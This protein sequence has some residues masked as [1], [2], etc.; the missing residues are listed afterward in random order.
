MLSDVFGWRLRLTFDA[1]TFWAHWLRNQE[2][3]GD[4]RLYNLVFSSLTFPAEVLG[5]L[6]NPGEAGL[7][8]Y[9]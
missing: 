8:S 7:K 3:A 6:L 4:N 5:L 9:E 2:A 1:A